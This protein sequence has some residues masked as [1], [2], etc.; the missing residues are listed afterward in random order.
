[1]G[2]QLCVCVYFLRGAQLDVVRYRGD[3]NLRVDPLFT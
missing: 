1:M 3:Q 2:S